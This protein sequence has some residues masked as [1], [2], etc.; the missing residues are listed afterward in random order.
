M[1][2]R[3]LDKG[4][5]ILFEYGTA[6]RL[7]YVIKTSEEHVLLGRKEWLVSSS[8]WESTWELNRK[9]FEFVKKTKERF[10][11]KFIPFINDC[12][13]PFHPVTIPKKYNIMKKYQSTLFASVS[14]MFPNTKPQ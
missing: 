2:S 14:K 12:I 13:C 11:W 7:F 1:D 4:D 6:K 5:W 10:W 8:L 3:E 9:G